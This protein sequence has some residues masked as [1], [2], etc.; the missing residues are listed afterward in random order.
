M[1][2]VLIVSIVKTNE[3]FMTQ[4]KKVENL[5][6]EDSMQELEAIVSAME[7][8]D[9]PLEEALTK[10]ERGIQLTNHSQQKL[11]QAEQKVDILLKQNGKEELTPFTP[12][13]PD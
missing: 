4:S 2:R 10:F 3:G 12:A 11:K 1:C 5:S 8:G 7:G 6:F 13:D 9:M